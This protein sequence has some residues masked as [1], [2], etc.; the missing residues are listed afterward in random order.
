MGKKKEIP[1]E[2]VTPVEAELP[3]GTVIT[4]LDVDPN[5]PR[6]K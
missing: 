1:V 6:N 3:A 2:V 4:H 5:D